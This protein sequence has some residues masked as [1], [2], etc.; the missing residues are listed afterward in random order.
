MQDRD[1]G[2][3]ISLLSTQPVRGSWRKAKGQGEAM[4]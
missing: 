1:K 2:E 4:T 3:S